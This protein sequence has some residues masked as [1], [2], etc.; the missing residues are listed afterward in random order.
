MVKKPTK[1]AKS[2]LNLKAVEA[3]IKSIPTIEDNNVFQLPKFAYKKIEGSFGI[4]T[5][6]ND[7][8]TNV[9][10]EGCRDR[11]HGS[12]APEA[13]MDFLFFHM[14]GTGKNVILFM[15]MVEALIKVKPE[16]CLEIH[17]TTSE[18]VLYIKMS[19]WWKYPLRRSLMTA[20]LR[21]GQM[22]T[23]HTSKGFEKA[24]F[25]QYYLAQTK[26]AV[27][28]FLGG[29]TASKLKKRVSQSFPGWYSHFANKDETKVKETLTRV[30]PDDH[31]KKP[32]KEVKEE[33]KVEETA[34]VTATTT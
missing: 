11:F 12:S 30:L 31:P 3:A 20:L 32:K 7:K 14:A 9:T 17:K 34:N 26:P 33:T 5:R 27:G 19:K 10:W 18:Q 2:A 28:A 15:K 1:K 21:A 6:S 8:V 23:D 22:F 25:A 24:L 16:D 13:M 29:R 4:M